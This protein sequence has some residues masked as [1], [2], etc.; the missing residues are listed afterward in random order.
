MENDRLRL[1]KFDIYTFLSEINVDSENPII[2]ILREYNPHGILKFWDF[3]YNE[4]EYL[5][6][7]TREAYW[8]LQGVVIGIEIDYLPE[9]I[10]L[11]NDDIQEAIK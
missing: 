4:K 10:G 11:F 6:L 2:T 9:D 3:E 1:S 7:N 8:F 5:T